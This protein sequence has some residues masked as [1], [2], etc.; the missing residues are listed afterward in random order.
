VRPHLDLGVH[1]L[2]TFAL[3]LHEQD[4]L[5]WNDGVAPETAIDFDVPHYSRAKGLAMWLGGLFFF[6]SVYQIAK[7]MNHPANKRS[8]DRDLPESTKTTALGNYGKY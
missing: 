8:A 1:S 7:L 3:Q 6:F 5:V 2:Y 4:E